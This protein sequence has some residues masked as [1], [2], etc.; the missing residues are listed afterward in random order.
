LQ[1]IDKLR[2]AHPLIYT[3]IRGK[4]LQLHKSSLVFHHR[5]GALGETQELLHHLV[6]NV[7]RKELLSE[8]REKILP[9]NIHPVLKNGAQSRSPPNVS[10]ILKSKGSQVYLILFWTMDSS[11]DLL[12]LTNPAL[13]HIEITL[14]LKGRRPHPAKPL[15][16]GCA[17][18]TIWI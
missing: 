4:L 3:D 9:S 6:L 16:D 11:K 2:C 10:S 13:R 5:H 1:T 12:R 17:I 8:N 18:A 14:P 7:P 15:H